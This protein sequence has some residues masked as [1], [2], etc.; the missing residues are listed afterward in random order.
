[1]RRTPLSLPSPST[2]NPARR[3]T[4]RPRSTVPM[5]MQRTPLSLP[6]PST[7]NPTRRTTRRPRSTVPMTMRRTPPSLPSQSTM[8]PTRRTTR[9]PRS[10]VPKTMKRPG[11][12]LQNNWSR[13]RVRIF[14]PNRSATR[15]LP[16][17]PDTAHRPFTSRPTATILYCN[18]G[19]AAC[20]ATS[21]TSI[22][23]CPTA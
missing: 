21:S 17:P 23:T 12:L 1:M 19:L 6:S 20:C 5:T 9:R 15:F 10:K 7:R 2:R 14:V 11:E 16:M 22:A 4:R 3:T 13:Q 18:C 8:N